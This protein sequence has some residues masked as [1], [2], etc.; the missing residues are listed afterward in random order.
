[1]E[2]SKEELEDKNVEKEKENRRGIY[3]KRKRL[4]KE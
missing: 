2:E 4:R 1:V 3:L